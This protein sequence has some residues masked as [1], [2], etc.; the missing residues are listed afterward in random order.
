MGGIL[1]RM[2]KK[3]NMVS[4]GKRNKFAN[5]LKPFCVVI[6]WN[7]ISELSYSNTFVTVTVIIS[8]SV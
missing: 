4:G 5:S 2:F 6:L 8:Y 7:L 3:L 1:K